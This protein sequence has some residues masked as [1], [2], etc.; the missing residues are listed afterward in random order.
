M[1]MEYNFNVRYNVTSDF[2]IIFRSGYFVAGDAL[3]VLLDSKYGR[4]LR[5]A[6]IVFEHRF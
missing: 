4:V 2:Q 6:F 3:F 5:E 1:G